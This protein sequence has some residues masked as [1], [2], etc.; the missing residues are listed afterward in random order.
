VRIAK[1]ADWGEKEI[2]ERQ[3]VLSGFA[4]AAWAF[5]M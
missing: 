1:A 4:K 5:L 3:T 2:S